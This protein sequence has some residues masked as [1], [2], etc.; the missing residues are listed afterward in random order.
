MPLTPRVTVQPPE[1]DGKN[2][3]DGN[4][5]TG[6]AAAATAGH[7][8]IPSAQSNKREED[9]PFPVGGGREYWCGRAVK[10]HIVA[11]SHVA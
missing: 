6:S 10:H 4:M 3:T 5:T 1:A 7:A 8:S 2:G 9:I 11:A